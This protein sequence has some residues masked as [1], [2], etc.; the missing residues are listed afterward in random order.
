MLD[1]SANFDLENAEVILCF[2]RL[3]ILGSLV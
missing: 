3:V 2:L 1:E